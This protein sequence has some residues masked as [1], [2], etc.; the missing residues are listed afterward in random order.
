MDSLASCSLL[1]VASVFFY[2]AIGCTL[3]PVHKDLT[4]LVRLF[5]KRRH[6]WM[7]AY[8][9]MRQ[10]RWQMPCIYLECQT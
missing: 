4:N 1:A 8:R 6:F 9:N 10:C 7:N 5:S 2:I 3:P